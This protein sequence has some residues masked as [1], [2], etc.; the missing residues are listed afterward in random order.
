MITIMTPGLIPIHMR[1]LLT[2]ILLIFIECG[3]IKQVNFANK[4]ADMSLLYDDL[5]DN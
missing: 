4:Q 5:G 1:S 2:K 3:I